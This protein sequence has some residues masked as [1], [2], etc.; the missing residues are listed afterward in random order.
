M[1]LAHVWR[2]LRLR[3]ASAILAYR[4]A[5]L[6][7]QRAANPARV[8]PRKI[9]PRD[10][11]VCLF[12]PPLVT[13]IVAFRHLLVLPSGVASR[14]RGTRTVVAPKVPK[15]LRS[16]WPC[17]E[18][19]APPGATAGVSATALISRSRRH[20]VEFDFQKLLY[21]AANARPHSNFQGIEPSVADKCSSSVEQ[22]EGFGPS[23]IIA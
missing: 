6:R 15:R 1:R 10:Q 4:A 17:R 22:A 8:G 14:A 5:E 9:R 12:R 19:T 23:I 20:R 2:N 21:E 13:G 11:G 7:L 18:P 3:S 16:R